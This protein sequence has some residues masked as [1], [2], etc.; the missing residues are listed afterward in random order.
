MKSDNVFCVGSSFPHFRRGCTSFED[1]THSQ[2]Y[3]RDA[4]TLTAAARL[5]PKIA[6]KANTDPT[7]SSDT[8]VSMAVQPTS[9]AGGARVSASRAARTTHCPQANG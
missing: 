8:R 5:T 2:F 1:N 7:T 9:V 4:R 3:T 6:E